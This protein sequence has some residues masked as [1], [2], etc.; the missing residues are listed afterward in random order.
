MS[1]KKIIKWSVIIG[2]VAI[3][4]LSLGVMAYIHS[5]VS[6]FKQIM[7]NGIFIEGVAVGGLTKEEAKDQLKGFL[8]QEDTNQF[9]VLSK[10]DLVEKIPYSELGTS[11]NLDEILEQ[12][13]AVGHDGSLLDQY[14]IYKEGLT[15][16]ENFELDKTYNDSLVLSK[17]E[18]LQEQV[19]VEPI[20]ASMTRKSKQ[21]TITPSKNGEKLNVEATYQQVLE[22]LKQT[23]EGNVE[24]EMVMETVKPKYTEELF[25]NSQSIVS[26]FS[27]SYNNADPDRNIN[28]A[29]AASKISRLLLP[30][31]TFYLS[32]RLEPF[33]EAAGYKSSKVIVNGKLED[34]IGGGVCQVASTLYNAVLLTELDITMRQNHSLSVSYVPLG[35]DAT[36]ATDVI[37]FQFKNNTEYPVYIDS[38]CAN[39]NVYVNLY[40]NQSLKTPYEIKFE[41]VVTEVIPAPETK[42]VDD[43]ELE[44]GKERTETTALEGKKVKLYK[45]YYKNGALQNKVL[46]NNSYYRP[47]AATIKRGTKK[48]VQEPVP[49]TNTNSTGEESISTASDNVL[50]EVRLALPSSNEDEVTNQADDLSDFQVIQQ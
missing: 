4:G 19:Y 7:A 21:F 41:S 23:Q 16:K 33:T 14:H 17:I 24:V 42:Y 48:V 3:G 28:L 39:N 50:P 37:D 26:S 1:N 36:Y 35:R 49:Q 15:N 45:L 8:Q 13:L 46:V 32:D 9:L 2:I 22:E 47:R 12:A 5:Q 34:G 31:E 18:S 38:Y 43:P 44:E 27:T 30:G 40:S 11:Y 10:G 20:N 29:V 6:E 25:Q